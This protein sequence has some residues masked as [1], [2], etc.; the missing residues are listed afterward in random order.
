MARAPDPVTAAS[1]SA[2]AQSIG[3]LLASTG[4]V[5]L[6]FLHTVTGAWTVPAAVLLAVVAVSVVTGWLAG[7]ARTVPR[8]RG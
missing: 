4:P 2:F 7:R 6:G 8:L 1:L 3:Y 5:A